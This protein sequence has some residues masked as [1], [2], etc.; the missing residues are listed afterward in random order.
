LG[1]AWE[2]EDVYGGRGTATGHKFDVGIKNV[3]DLL[4]CSHKLKGHVFAGV[5]PLLSI[6]KNKSIYTKIS[7]KKFKF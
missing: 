6:S 1:I 3:F 2:L 7:T 5:S 4:R